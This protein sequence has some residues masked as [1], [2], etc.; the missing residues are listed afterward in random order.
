[1]GFLWEGM[2]PLRSCEKYPERLSGLILTAT[3]AADDSPQGKLA[4]DQAADNARTRGIEAI[5]H[6]MLPRMFA[7]DTM[8]QKPVL[9]STVRDIMST[10]SLNGVLGDLAALKSRQDSRPL[11]GSIKCPVLVLHGSE[12][13]IV[14]LQEAEEMQAAV[15][16]SKFHQIPGAGHLLNLE[17]PAH[18]NQAL[19][20]FLQNLDWKD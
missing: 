20:D 4:R 11:L 1:M 10:T 6:S 17:H 12:D 13:Q 15:P 16:N 14:P 19:Q 7:P 3:R 8:A 2:F 18:F 9:V 5:V